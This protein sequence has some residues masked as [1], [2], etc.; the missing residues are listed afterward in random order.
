MDRRSFLK[1]SATAVAALGTAGYS[2]AQ[3][4]RPN[5]IFILA[6][7]MGWG[8]LG[9]YGNPKVKTPNIDK[10]ANEGTCFTNFYVNSPVCSPTRAAIMTGQFPSRHRMHTQIFGSQQRIEQMKIAKFLDPDVITLPRILKDAGYQTAHIGKWHLSVPQG[11]ERSVPEPQRYGID[12]ARLPDF[13]WKKLG[14]EWD[15]QRSSELYTD[16]AIDF[17]DKRNVKKPFFMQIW[18][19]DPHN[20]YHPTKQQLE[21]YP[22][23]PV[24]D[25]L[26]QYWSLVTEIDRNVG[27][28]ME[29][30][31]QTGLDKKTFVIFTS[32][33]GPADTSDL[34]SNQLAGVGSAGPFRGCK[35]SLYEGGIRTP[36]IVSSPVRVPAGRI[37]EKTVLSGVDILPTLCS[38]ARVE[39]P[40]DYKSDG[41]D[42]S[43][44][45]FGKNVTRNKPLMWFYPIRY[46]AATIN[47][48]PVLTIRQGRWKLLIN[49]DSSR[50]EL[51]NLDNDLTETNNLADIYT[52]ITS[53]LGARLL[54][55]Y[56]SLPPNTIEPGA[57]ELTFPWPGNKWNSV[58]ES[59][60]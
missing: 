29:K 13:N 24:D 34:S 37:D 5:F 51:Y 59:L 25:K 60:K 10:L 32:D 49:A 19:N 2:S 28:I 18:F 38:L 31:K 1:M 54:N 26:K 4:D 58:T 45:F 46:R 15:H 30:L 14:L 55:W 56:S 43:A 48:S 47:Q 23:M 39:L 11:R 9:C 44:A 21:A 50:P 33:N 57:G 3:N 53:D 12:F 20:P 17:V 35:G 52:E 7:D 42:V 22:E 36:F 41:E 40:D 6:D 8:D 16:Q 27:R